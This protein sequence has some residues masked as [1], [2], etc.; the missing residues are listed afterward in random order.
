MITYAIFREP[1]TTHHQHGL[2]T[3]P[4]SLCLVQR[5][6]SV[7]P[8]RCFAGFSSSELSSDDEKSSWIHL[9][10]QHDMS[11]PEKILCKLLEIPGDLL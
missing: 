8:G 2:M 11:S 1:P 4:S 9:W 10:T 7:T 5:P 3:C 6:L